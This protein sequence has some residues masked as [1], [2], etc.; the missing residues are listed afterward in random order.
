MLKSP[1]VQKVL[2]NSLVQKIIAIYKSATSG[3]GSLFI[4]AFSYSL[5]LGLAPFLIIA[6]MVIGNYVFSVDQIVNLM[7]QY[8]PK[9]LI[10]PFI[11]YILINDFD[12][13]WALFTLLGASVWVASKSIYSF[14]VNSSIRDEVKIYGFVLRIISLIYFIILV[15]MII[16]CGVV[17]SLIDIPNIFVMPLLLFVF[18]Y[19]FYRLLSFRRI[20]FRELA[21]GAGFST[22]AILLVG[23][24]FFVIVNT[25][26]NY[27]TIYGPFASLMILLLSLNVISMIIYVGYLITNVFRDV[28]S[29][30][31][32]G[33]VQKLTK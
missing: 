26:F 19:I 27:D 23:Q 15:L 17:V 20:Q 2:R 1:A 16:V 33:I 31:K 21:L 8:I 11:S 29:P 12:S 4:Y 30:I 3:E 24:L 28:H 6:V 10:D 5:L 14:L 7:T 13:W 32:S 22:I 25:F 9:Q 18:F